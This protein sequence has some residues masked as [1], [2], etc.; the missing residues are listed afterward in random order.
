MSPFTLLHPNRMG[1]FLFSCEHASNALPSSI[2]TSEKDRHFLSTH[3]GWDIGVASVT[4]H[5]IEL[6]QSQGIFSN[7]S[8]LWVDLNRSKDR[9]DLIRKETEGHILSFNQHLTPSDEIQR[10]QQYYSPYHTAFDQLVQERVQHTPPVLLISMHS[11]TPVWN[12]A[13]RNMDIGVLFDDC[14]TLG[15]HLSRLLRKE[16]LFVACNQPYTGKGGL[17]FSVEDK[18]KRHQCAHLELEI[19]QALICTPERQ[20][21]V[22]LKI[23]NALS[24]LHKSVVN[25]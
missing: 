16:S 23:Y 20:R 11:F 18:G 6:T 4:R 2:S 25:F 5:L 3:W 1:P 13:V 10:L 9:T 17:M 14:E 22:A 12:G 19:N 15:L 8:R 21:Y 7:F 24:E